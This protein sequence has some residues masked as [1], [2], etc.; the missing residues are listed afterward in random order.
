MN[1][2]LGEQLIAAQEVKNNDVNS[3][4]WKEARN[5]NHEQKEVKLVDASEEELKRYMAHCKSMLYSTDKD[6]PGRYTLLTIIE[7]QKNRC[8][9]ELFLRWLENS[10][11][12]TDRTPIKRATYLNLVNTFFTNNVD[13]LPTNRKEINISRFTNGVPTEFGTLTADLIIDACIGRLGVF[14]K[15]HITLKFIATKLG[16]WFTQQEMNEFTDESKKVGKSRIELVKERCGLNPSISITVKDNK[17]L[18]FKEFRALVK[19]KNKKYDEM[20]TDQL[21]VLRDKGLFGLSEEVQRHILQWKTIIGQIEKVAE[22]KGYTL[23]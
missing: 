9:A 7:D 16:L 18:N 11:D 4:V 10:Y 23:E 20:T 21:L 3:F 12:V 22:L 1:S 19:L 5:A 13:V 17:I 2:T 8:N 6:N 14:N 15:K